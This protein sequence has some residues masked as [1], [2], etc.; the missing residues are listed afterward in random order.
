MTQLSLSN[1]PRQVLFRTEEVVFTT[2]GLLFHF[3]SILP[4]IQREKDLYGEY[5]G[6]LMKS[7]PHFLIER[8]ALKRCHVTIFLEFLQ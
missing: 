3:S 1:S 4:P 8:I 7:Q 6:S 2:S 5:N